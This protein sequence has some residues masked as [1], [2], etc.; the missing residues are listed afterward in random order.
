MEASGTTSHW[1]VISLEKRMGTPTPCLAMSS[2]GKLA[3][4]GTEMLAQLTAATRA[5]TTARRSMVSKGLA[6]QI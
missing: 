1:L 4:S 3:V 2:Y 5:A 6:A